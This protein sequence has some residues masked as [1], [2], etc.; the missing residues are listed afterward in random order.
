[1]ADKIIEMISEEEILQRARELAAEID[2]D[3]GGEPIHLVGILKGSVYFICELSKRI[4]SPVT[5]DF[6]SVSSYGDGMSSSG[7]V[8]IV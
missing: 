8:R 3:Y 5:I 7:V 1:M 6:M 2:R 4:Q